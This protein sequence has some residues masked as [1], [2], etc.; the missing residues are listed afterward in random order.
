MA[1]EASWDDME[2]ISYALGGIWDY[3]GAPGM[4]LE[5]SVVA[6]GRGGPV[7][8]LEADEIE[9][10]WDDLRGIWDDLAGTWEGLVSIWDGLEGT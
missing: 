4:A 9:G 3:L 10:T 5:A 7:K 8:A 2:G 6:W 1:W